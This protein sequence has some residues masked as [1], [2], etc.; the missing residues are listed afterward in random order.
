M[1]GFGRELVTPACPGLLAGFLALFSL[2]PS[3]GAQTEGKYRFPRFCAN[4]AAT[5]PAVT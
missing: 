3:G 1:R 4:G 5:F 2:P